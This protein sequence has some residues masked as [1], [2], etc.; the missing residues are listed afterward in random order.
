[1]KFIRKFFS[2]IPFSKN[3]LSFILK[4]FPEFIL[5]TH[6][7]IKLYVSSKDIKNL[8]DA[9]IPTKNNNRIHEVFSA[10]LKE[11]YT[12]IDVGG[13]IGLF[14]VIASKKCKSVHVF[15]PDPDCFKNIEKNLGYHRLD[16]LILNQLALSNMNEEKI[17][18]KDSFYS[19]LGSFALENIK[20]KESVIKIKAIKLDDYVENKINEPV[21]FIK[22]NIQGAEGHAIEGAKNLI[23]RDLPIVLTEFWP[24]GLKNSGYEPEL[25]ISFFQKLKYE[26]VQVNQHNLDLEKKNYDDLIEVCKNLDEELVLYFLLQNSNSKDYH[27]DLDSLI[28]K[29]LSE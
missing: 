20:H 26:F 28:D 12:V 2:S 5:V 29:N 21:N 3:L 14:S 9:V 6:S 22:L 27:E 24:Y 8:I 15:E 13:N 1:M 18:F 19:T 11:D 4:L 10:L 25:L 16:N 17:F 23:S 7:K